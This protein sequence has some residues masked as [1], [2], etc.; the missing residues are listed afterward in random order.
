MN[1]RRVLL[2]SLVALSGAVAVLGC[3]AEPRARQDADWDVWYAGDRGGAQRAAQP[4]PAPPP[5]ARPAQPAARPA[6]PAARPA[7]AP[8]PAAAGMI[9]GK[10]YIPTGEA[11]TSALLVEKLQ[12]GEVVAGRPFDYEIRVTNLSKN[13]LEGVEVTETLSNNLKLAE[14]PA[15]AMR[16]GAVRI[17]VGALNPGETRSFKMNA[18]ASGGESIRNCVTATYNTTLCLTSPVVAPALKVTKTAPP[19]VLVCDLIPMRIVVTNSGTGVARNVR[20]EDNLPAGMTVDG[21]NAVTFD[22]GSLA[23][24]QSREIQFNAKVAKPGKYDNKVT[25]KAEGDM[26]AESA[27]V[28]TVAKQP[29]LAIT[30][31]GPEKLFIGRPVNYEITVTNKGD[32]VA[33]ETVVTDTLPAGARVTAASDNGRAAEGKVVWALGEMA[34]GASKKL[35]LTLVGEVGGVM[36]NQAVA[37]AKCADAVTATAQT[38]LAGIPAILLEVVDLTDPTEVGKNHTYV[39]TAT[40]QGSADDTNVKIVATLEQTME[41]VSA[42]GATRGAHAN[43]VITFEP[44]PN[45]P[46]KQKAT[47]TV[48]VKAIGEGD[49]RFKI[50]MNSDNLTRPV[51]ETESSSFYK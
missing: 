2:T 40:N 1:I 21:K 13:K 51:E 48:V 27:V 23:A 17:N 9:S 37:T 24:G 3:K 19:E 46:P 22:V 10:L 42:T 35:T 36:R 5:A 11:S 18:T 6:E 43:R 25:A 15:A 44:L 14:N 33:R 8:A 28:S 30:K 4:A 50:A 45:L 32:G 47:W 41:F 26:T 20:V 49:A 38:E 12:P 39:I 34:P 31:T 29:V 16:D 7:P